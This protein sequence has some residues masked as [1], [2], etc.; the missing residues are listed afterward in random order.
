MLEAGPGRCSKQPWREDRLRRDFQADIQG[1]WEHRS[2]REQ[3]SWP[4][5]QRSS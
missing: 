3:L 1:C 4:S 5:N 2:Q